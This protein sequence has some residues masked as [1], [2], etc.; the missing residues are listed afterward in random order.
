MRTDPG[1]VG[2]VVD[3]RRR[4]VHGLRR[5]E[6]AELAGIST[7]YYTRLE[8][9]RERHPSAQVLDAIARA[10]QLTS[11][12]TGHL[13]LVTGQAA[14]S[15]ANQPQT[16]LGSD[17]RALLHP[18][19]L[20]IP[21]AVLG[22]ALDIVYLNSVGAAFYSGFSR[23]DNLLRMVFGDPAA[24]VFYD[25]WELTARATVASLRASSA[26]F[27]GDP[28]I[29]EIVSELSDSSESF[30]QLWSAHEIRLSPCPKTH[31]MHHPD[32]GDLYL[33]CNTF[34]VVSMPGQHLHVFTPA[35]GSTSADRIEQLARRG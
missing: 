24:A 12:E 28:H 34:E 5:E 18:S 20:R 21:V 29:D 10:L 31:L 11:E 9:G 17:L 4:Q 33:Y 7:D 26:Q 23:T 6:V 22:R 30:A 3:R 13:F 27:P 16:E 32:L 8:Q 15:A 25:E 14:P 1:S 19:V 2:L 35:P